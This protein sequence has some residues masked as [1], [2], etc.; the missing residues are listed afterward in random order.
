MQW[1]VKALIL[2]ALWLAAIVAIAYV[3][4]DVIL[5]GTITDAEDAAIAERYGFLCGLGLPVL[6]GIC[7]VRR[8]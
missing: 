2:S 5:A 8:S 6:W 4:T 3:H 7:F 1:W